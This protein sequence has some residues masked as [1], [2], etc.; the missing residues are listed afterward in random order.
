MPIP[1]PRPVAAPPPAPPP[2]GLPTSA[3]SP[4]PAVPTGGGGDID[5]DNLIGDLSGFGLGGSVAPAAAPVGVSAPLPAISAVPASLE[6]LLGQDPATP[7]FAAPVAPPRP[8]EAAPPAGQPP[9]VP[10]S[11]AAVAAPA[12]SVDASA[13]AVPVGTSAPAGPVGT[14]TN[15]ASA[16]RAALRSFQEGAGIP[17]A[18]LAADPEATLRAAGEVFAIMTLGLREVLMARREIKGGMRVDQTMMASDN[19]NALKFSHSGEAALIAMLTLNGRGYM[20]PAKAAREACDDIKMHELAMMAGIRTAL[21]NLVQRFDPDALE[22]RIAQSMLGS[23][24][25]AA[26]KARLWDSFRE[27]YATIAAETED[28]FQAVFGKSFAKS[29]TA[30]TKPG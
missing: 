18:M 8:A 19:N 20:K 4:L 22:K 28:D 23:V 2:R 26:R 15:E 21:D 25:P 30:H 5:F 3:P 17:D 7:A 11:L 27:I 9:I 1:V 10:A 16:M 13:P 29:Y 14:L 6:G 24:L 12:V